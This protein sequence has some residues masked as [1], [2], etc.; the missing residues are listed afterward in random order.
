VDLPPLS[1]HIFKLPECKIQPHCWG[2]QLCVER[3]T[4]NFKSG[5]YF[6]PEVMSGQP[7]LDE[8]VSEANLD[9]WELKFL[10]IAQDTTNAFSCDFLVRGA[11]LL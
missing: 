4:W 6:S 3:V 2:L 5:D 9:L 11:A 10:A 1:E 8:L 7:P